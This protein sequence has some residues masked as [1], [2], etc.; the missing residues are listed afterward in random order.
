MLG[1]QV[2][3]FTRANDTEDGFV[4]G[5]YT[6]ASVSSFTAGELRSFLL[7]VIIRLALIVPE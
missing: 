4:S 5:S 1:V 3:V 7:P 6:F 2:L